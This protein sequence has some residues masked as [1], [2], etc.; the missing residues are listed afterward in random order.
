MNDET[1]TGGV[2][3]VIVIAF[4]N[5]LVGD[6]STYS[7]PSVTLGSAAKYRSS[8]HP[9][10]LAFSLKYLWP[11][12]KNKYW[13]SFCCGLRQPLREIFDY[14]PADWRVRFLFIVHSAFY[15]F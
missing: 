10:M 1:T 8:G 14:L 5:F 12:G 7:L 6:K 15:R 4:A 2:I 11:Q 9:A 3:I 13:L